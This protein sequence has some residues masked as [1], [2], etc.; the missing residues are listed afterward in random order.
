MVERCAKELLFKHTV[1]RAFFVSHVIHDTS[2]GLELSV[3]S[4]KRVIPYMGPTFDP[5]GPSVRPLPYLEWNP[6]F[7]KTIL[8]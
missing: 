1:I 8:I 3:N 6:P 2:A 4:A 7:F 5:R